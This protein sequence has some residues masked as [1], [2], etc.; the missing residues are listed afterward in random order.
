MLVEQ[1]YWKQNIPGGDRTDFAC[2]YSNLSPDPLA[3]VPID[4]V[5]QYAFE[6]VGVYGHI[7]A[8]QFAETEFDW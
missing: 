7:F 6:L 5:R 8:R 3:E 4:L 2:E 1:E